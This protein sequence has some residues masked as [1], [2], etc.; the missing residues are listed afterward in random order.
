MGRFDSP[1]KEA[2]TSYQCVNQ[3]L[4]SGNLELVDQAIEECTQALKSNPEN[5]EAHHTLGLALKRK[6][7]RQDDIKNELC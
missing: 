1:L 2:S 5:S 3:G 4:P 7:L 6:R